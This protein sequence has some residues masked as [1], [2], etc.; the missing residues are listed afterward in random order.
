MPEND[1][2][3]EKAP[4][5]RRRWKRRVL[6]VL[7]LLL[8]IS[9]VVLNGPGWRWIAGRVA[10][11]YLPE[12]G[13]TGTVDFGGTLSKGEI[14]LRGV[15][16]KGEGAVKSVKL[17][18]VVL[19]YQPSRVIHGEIEAVRIDGLHAELDLDK[20]WP[21][22]KKPKDTQEKSGDFSKLSETL[23]TLRQ[24]IVPVE[25]DISDLRVAVT[26]KGQTVFGLASMDLKHES[27]GE[28]F[29]LKLGDLAFSNGR[30][31]PAQETALVWRNEEIEVEK[32]LLLPGITLEGVKAQL[33][34]SGA[35]TY[36]GAIRVN[37][38]RLSATGSLEEARLR[39]ADGTLVAKQT[40]ALFGAEIPADATLETF[41]VQARG[42]KGGLKTLDG[43]VRAGLRGISF[44]DWQ[45]PAL[46][47]NGE[48][49]GPDLRADVNAEAL[50]SPLSIA[51]R[52][53]VSRDGGLKFQQATADIRVPQ[54]AAVLANL[55]TR[56]KDL[57]EPGPVP[58]S[59]LQGTVA[60]AFT[61]GKVSKADARFT[62]A[63]AHP[64]EVSSLDVT[65]GWVPQGPV[66]ARVVIDGGQIDATVDPTARRYKGRAAF[67][68]F[69][70]DRLHGWLAAFAVKV[71]PEMTLSGTWEG[72]G[73]FGPRD[74]KGHAVIGNFISAKAANGPLT[75]AGDVTYDWPKNAEVRGLTV[76]QGPEKFV[77]NAKLADQLLTL[78]QLQWTEGTEVL[79]DGKASVPVTENP[80]DWKSL[81]K[82]TRPLSVDIESRELALSKLHSFLPPTTRFPET[83]RGK[84]VIRLSGTPAEPQIDAQVIARDLG[85]ASQ[86]KVPK[87]DLD[88]TLKTEAGE[89]NVAGT[90]ATPGYPAAN[91]SAKLP[92]RPGVWV[93]NPAVLKDEKLE[94]AARVPNLELARFAALAP[95]VKTLAGSLKVDLTVGGTIGKPEPL[96][97]VELKG[98][99]V[100]LA[101]EAVPPLQGIGLKASASPAG[102]ILERVGLQ[103]D[104]GT[105]EGRGKLNLV[106]GKPSD[107]DVTL[108]GRALPLKR[109]DS[110]IIRSDMDIAIRGPWQTAT[111]SGTVAIVDSLFY[112][113]IELLPIGVPFNQPSAPSVP[114]IDTAKKDAAADALPE[115][116]R[117]WGLAVKAKTANAFLIRGN[118]ATGQAILDVNVGGTL[119]KPAPKG[120]AILRDVS[121]K[122]PFSTL[123]VEEGTVDFRPEA[124]F[125]PT[126]NIRGRSVVRPYEVNVYVYG[127]VSDPKVLTTSNP[128]MPESEVMTLLATGTTT[129]G[130]ADPQ[131]ATTRG[132][133]LLIEELR[134]GRIRFAK[135]L[136]PLLKILDRVD[137]QIGEQN[138][139]SGEKMNSATINLDDNWLISAGMGE[140][141]RSRV[142]LMYLVRFR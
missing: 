113:D 97:A 12:L 61:D 27:G 116:F 56:M 135:R 122:L 55:R 41:E 120:Q 129:S 112:R 58:E 36:D 35:L 85:L 102:I 39:L 51:A 78:D 98:G 64:E 47:L 60:A 104:G 10:A 50:G 84:L 119:G 124:P 111:V 106:E 33:P 3:P 18:Q 132:A 88:L 11:H 121:A 2:P 81:L 123:L 80:A 131:A 63:P 127:S 110:M 31:L 16:L 8:G 109:D 57:K 46:R 100:T 139:Y 142:M 62:L 44:Q 108:R 69:T 5:K 34:A 126:L 114:A 130:I 125:D 14:L 30:K 54:A 66:D 67:N 53:M 40:A 134:R 17:E 91:L 115:P 65:A 29:A 87:A 76:T 92:F 38:A 138:R 71:P 136:Q 22:P 79:L 75:A 89:L 70:P 42:F 28:R 24:R 103:M 82:Q 21:G 86:P 137:F 72:E 37:D 107:I 48:L 1:A 32:A 140:E 52:S 77:C 26:Q 23:R 59:A 73:G 9:L 68:D 96:G 118:L 133:Q 43:T 101:S 99:G 6:L 105:F 7:A 20:P 74:H 90:L 4:R 141:G 15:D 95:G 45:V 117:N 128:P 19:R 94:A 83:A 49:K 13:L 93:E 25:A